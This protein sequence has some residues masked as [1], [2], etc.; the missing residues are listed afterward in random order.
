M[1]H[2]LALQAAATGTNSWWIP[3]L[4]TPFIAAFGWLGKT[5][6][7]S[8]EKERDRYRDIVLEMLPKQTKTVR[9]RD[10][11][12]VELQSEIARL[13]KRIEEKVAS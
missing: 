13:S 4:V 5:Y 1:L 7:S 12:I 2:A 9:D 6:I 10:D 8:V 3:V 11:T